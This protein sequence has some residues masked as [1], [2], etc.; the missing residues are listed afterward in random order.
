[1]NCECWDDIVGCLK[2]QVLSYG[3]NH[4]TEIQS[5][6]KVSFYRNF[7]GPVAVLST[8]TAYCGLHTIQYTSGLRM[9]L[10]KQIVMFQLMRNV[11]NCWPSNTNIFTICKFISPQ[12]T[13]KLYNF[14]HYVFWYHYGK[15]G[16]E[17]IML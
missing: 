16:E 17:R 9:Y 14:S 7:L 15:W 1:L 5:T 6:T 10:R 3:P 13:K 8:L 12:Q 11:N 4:G 2:L